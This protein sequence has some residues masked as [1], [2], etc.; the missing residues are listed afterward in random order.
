MRI[1]LQVWLVIFMVFPG[2]ARAQIQDVGS[3]AT[4]DIATWNIE[5][6]G[7]PSNGP[8]NDT[9]QL[10]N[11]ADIVSGSG[12]DLWAVQEIARSNR[13]DDLLAGLPDY[14]SGLLATDSGEQRIGFLWD[15]RVL[16]L[17]QWTHILQSFDYE[18]AGRP[19]LKAEFMVTLPDTSF[20][21]S[22]IT[23]HMK[24]FSD[25]TSYERRTEAAKRIKNHIDFTGL[26]T[27]PVFFLGDYN[28]ELL[29]STYNGQP[30]PYQPFI[31]DPGDYEVLTL[32]LEE[33]G[34][35]SFQSGSFLDHIIVSN[36]ADAMW[37]SG[38]TRVLT[39][40]VTVNSFYARTSDHVPVV[41][42]FG[43][44]TV[45]STEGAADLP[46]EMVLSTPWPNPSN[47]LIS[48]EYRANEPDARIHVMDIL[49]RIVHEAPVAAGTNGLDMRALAPGLYLIR[50]TDRNG[51]Y[52]RTVLLGR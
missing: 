6:F 35:Y 1:L 2:A 16:G 30:S 14:W 11:V 28:D 9:V 32:P 44:S 38:S 40:L 13:F 23:V 8:S 26:A 25:R 12:V 42:S 43:P 19:P 47:G 51:T 49:G 37:I 4:L 21:A 15:T 31:D 39:N 50:L 17:R 46:D 10:Q 33:A 29:S 36:E 7:H 27:Q 52:D 18:F 41:A 22:F 5:W 34:G 20:I 3:D 48:L 24:A 45:T